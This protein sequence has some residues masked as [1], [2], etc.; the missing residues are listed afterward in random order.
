MAHPEHHGRQPRR[1]CSNAATSRPANKRRSHWSGGRARDAPHGHRPTP[2]RSIP[3]RP[4]LPRSA[5]LCPALPR[6]APLCP[7]LPSS[8]QPRSVPLCPASSAPSRSAPLCPSLPFSALLCPSLPFSAPLC[9]ALPLS[10]PLCPASSAPPALPR[11]GPL[12]PITVAP[13]GNPCTH[14]SASLGLPAG[15]GGA[16][17]PRA[18]PCLVSLPRGAGQR[19]RASSCEIS[20]AKPAKHLPHPSSVGA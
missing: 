1:Y 9:P 6:S 2:P 13:V 4:V 8:A 19:V 5:P 10:V 15:P 12:C 11:P 16:T 3:P 17:R 7:A 14:L 18:L 20:H